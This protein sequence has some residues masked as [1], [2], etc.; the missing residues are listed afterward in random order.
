ML[1]CQ[2]TKKDSL[3]QKILNTTTCDV[4]NYRI[5]REIKEDKKIIKK[6]YIN[7]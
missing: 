5:I 2:F 7:N 3:L 6:L 1:I 4:F